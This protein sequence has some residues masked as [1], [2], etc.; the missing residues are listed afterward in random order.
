MK[1]DHNNS[2]QRAAGT[3]LCATALD[4][5]GGDVEK[6]SEDDW[7]CEPFLNGQRVT[8]F[9]NLHVSIVARLG[10]QN[11]VVASQWE[12]FD[13]RFFALRAHGAGFI[14]VLREPFERM[15]S[16]MHYAR[17]KYTLDDLA[18]FVLRRRDNPMVRMFARSAV[19][20]NNVTR[21]HLIEAQSVLERFDKVALQEDL[22]RGH[23]GANP[24][25][26]RLN[27]TDRVNERP[28]TATAGVPSCRER[29]LRTSPAQVADVDAHLVWD[30]QL[31]AY[32]SELVRA[33]DARCARAGERV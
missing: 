19:A 29:L 12:A 10:L 16:W 1:T 17:P 33:R 32:A 13:P 15:C 24:W 9:V 8:S 7:T 31:Y 30:R 23:F 28:N 11:K 20:R 26:W 22:A 6:A 14:A 27:L 21:D 3:W 25:H 4:N 18:G 2:M 5:L